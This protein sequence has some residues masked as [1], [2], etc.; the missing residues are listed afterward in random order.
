MNLKL[1]APAALL[2]LVACSGGSSGSNG[3]ASPSPAPSNPVAFP[4][5]EGSSVLA[6][7]SFRQTVSAQ[8]KG[9]VNDLLGQSSGT[10]DGHEVVAGTLAVM[11]ALETWLHDI[12]AHPPEGW[13]VAASGD[14]VEAVRTR[15]RS[16]GLDFAVFQRTENGKQHGVVVLAV[17]PKLLDEKAGPVLGMV[18]KFKLLPP[19]LRDPID[20]QAKQ[21]IGFTLT[22]LTQPNSP[23]GAAFDSLDDLRAYGGRGVVLVDA[24]KQ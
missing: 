14:S 18:G 15:T 9:G 19:S 2:V 17:D 7:H 11:P 21:Q 24:V 23:I 13:T 8:G 3:A 20:A 5:F 22:E 10:Y 4:L 12:T 6:A 1:L 16:M